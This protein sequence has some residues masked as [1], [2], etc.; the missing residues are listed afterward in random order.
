LDWYQIEGGREDMAD[1]SHWD[2]AQSFSGLEAAALILG[3]EP[4]E[5]E[6]E[7][8]RIQVLTKRME[9][10]YKHAHNRFFLD[11]A[12]LI[13]D[14]PCSDVDQQV[15]L[16]SVKMDELHRLN[17]LLV[18][19]LPPDEH[20]VVTPFYNWLSS[21]QQSNFENQEFSRLE[22]AGWL[23]AIGMQSIYSFNQVEPSAIAAP[24]GLWPWGSH[25]TEMLGHLAAAARRFWVN[26]DPGDLST[27]NTNA[28]VVDW[29][30]TDRKVSGK[31]A[32]AI[33]TMLRPD[34]LPTGPR[35]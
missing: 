6:N 17:P 5:S 11:L 26:Y 12:A 29:L 2:F 1:L 13:D 30:R 27:A 10:H 31:M 18:K 25:H 24:A 35:K 4:S 20:D 33:A 8:G 22:V 3:L 14:Q 9:L 23:T 7:H 21:Q 34:G 15:E 28:T 19:S 16:I 32:E